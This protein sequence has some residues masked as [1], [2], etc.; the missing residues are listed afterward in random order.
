MTRTRLAVAAAL[1]L[2]PTLSAQQRSIDDF[3]RDFTAEWVRGNPNLATS[4]RYF[5][6]EE[7]DRL[8]RQ[9]TPETLAYRRGRI[10]LARKGLAGLSQFDRS[11]L[12]ETQRVSADLMQ[13]QLDTVVREEPYLDY[14]F[15]LQQMSG[16]NINLVEVL[17][18]RHPLGS[19]KDAVNYLAALGQVGAR[20]DEA[21]AESRRLAAKNFIPPKFILEAT[22]KQMQSFADPAPAQNPFV[23]VFEQKMEAVKAI[24]DARR[25]E[26]RSQAEKIVGT[27]IYPAWKRAIAVLESQLP[28]STDDAGLWRLKGGADAYAYFLGRYTTTHL[29][30]D[31]VHQIGLRE[32]DRI[33]KQMDAILRRLRRTQG[34][35]KDRVAK[36]QADLGYPKTEEGRTLIMADVE[37]ILRDAEKRSAALFDKTPKSPVIARPFPRFREANAAANYNA[38]A[39]DGSRPGVF[40]IP[41]RPERM[42]KFGLRSLVYHETVPG[43]HFQIA[44]QVENKSLP[45]FRQ[46]G[47][48]GGISAL[49]EGWGLYAERLTAE[50]GWY[51]GDQE[52]LLGQLDAALFRARR[53][54]VDTGL[55]SQ[56]WTRQQAIDYGIEASEVE[57]YA[58]FP[59]QACSYMIGQLKIVEVR[60]KAQKAL[61]GKFS[62]RAFHDVVLD[63][64]TVPL[65]LLERQVDAYIRANGG[66]P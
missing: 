11:R 21:I 66:K 64:G 36:L 60:E 59:G 53:L 31:E 6:G 12:N 27:E 1:L 48:F 25:A 57:R 32:V 20:M 2:A 8:E 62:L 47:A 15:P 30:A 23:A 10:E 54:V 37:K 39:P 3:F 51:E 7:Q 46:I 24:S 9:L 33:E 4:S 52:G 17:T 65:E 40:Q 38:P 22:I 35:V 34:S 29:T 26:L 41:L 56:H 49:S 44:L 45:R 50:S 58:V 61:G 43:H 55:H 63:T 42:T 16:A 5:S 14:S 19:E 13:W 28:R 18:V